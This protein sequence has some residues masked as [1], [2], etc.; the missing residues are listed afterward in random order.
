M[1]FSLPY[2][3][4]TAIEIYDILGRK[5]KTLIDSPLNAGVHSITWHGESD[6]GKPVSSGVYFVRYIAGELKGEIRII[7]LK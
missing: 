7:M 5:L 3:S 4:P 6:D 2:K 1:R